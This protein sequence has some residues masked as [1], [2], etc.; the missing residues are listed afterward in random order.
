[1]AISPVSLSTNLGASATQAAGST[2][3]TSTSGTQSATSS[4]GLGLSSSDFLKLFLAQLQNQNPLEPTS[5]D[6]F[7]Q[8][9]AQFSTVEGINQM[10]Q[11][12][13]QLLS[14]QQLTQ[15][16]DLI[17]KKV[18][19]QKAGADGLQTG[20]VS[21]VNIVNGQAQLTV[22]SDSVTLQQVQTIQAA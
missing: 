17:G 1:M 5:S 11:D 13:S 10:N 9:T 12:I 7:L 16:A 22:G 14:F 8:Q 3:A 15:G 6:Q 20:V 18:S 21:G 2:S 19:Y 4:G